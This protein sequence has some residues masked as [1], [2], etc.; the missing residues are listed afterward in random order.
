MY[1]HEE[2]TNLFYV[3][4]DY[5]LAHCISADFAL[6]AGI[7]KQFTE[8]YQ[9]RQ[10]L[11]NGYPEKHNN[12]TG[13]GYCLITMNNGDRKYIANLVTKERYYYKPT[14]Q[15]LTESLES[16][17]YILSNVHMTEKIAMPMIGCG[18]DRLDWLNVSQVICSV[19]KNMP[20][21]ILVCYL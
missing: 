17:K 21:E 9:V 4:Q 14:Y 5:M 12:W 20:I 15:T 18:L 6:G 7:A 2:K 8:K 11:L 16:L 1:Y 3:P 13:T 19:F 10:N